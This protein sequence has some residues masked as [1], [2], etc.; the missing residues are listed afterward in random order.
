MRLSLEND[1]TEGDQEAELSIWRIKSLSVHFLTD[2]F[3]LL[4]SSNTSTLDHKLIP[5]TI[6]VQ[7]HQIPELPHDVVRGLDN[8]NELEI[9]VCNVTKNL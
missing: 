8:H 6:W 4:S 7:L 1:K 2:N 5:Q 9:S 3:L